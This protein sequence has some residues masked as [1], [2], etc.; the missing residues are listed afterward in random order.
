MADVVSI[1]LE[2]Y[3]ELRAQLDPKIVDKAATRALGRA[4]SAGRTV[5]A[6][7]IYQ[8]YNIKKRDINRAVKA[9][10]ANRGT[11]GPTA[12][13]VAKGRS[14]SLTYFGAKWYRT[15]SVTT[16]NKSTLRKRK[17]G[18]TG[19]YAKI[20]RGG[21]TTHKPHAFIAAVGTK[22]ADIFHIGVFER[23]PGSRMASNPKKEKIVERKLITIASMFG[24]SGAWDP[25]VERITET[26]N[27][28]FPRLINVLFGD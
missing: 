1:K 25:T 13:I 10:K 5:A 12:S 18:R 14:M 16:R 24:Q 7:K 6:D 19:V 28:E 3:D 9:V 22:R 4:V 20:M 15:K 26:W 21:D 23:V 2:G 17:T 8:K 27:S 11:T